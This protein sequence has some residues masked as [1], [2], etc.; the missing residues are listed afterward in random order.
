MLAALRSLQAACDLRA[1][2]SIT[3]QNKC[4]CFQWFSP[5]EAVLAI[6]MLA[7]ALH[8]DNGPFAA[9]PAGDVIWKNYRSGFLPITDR[10]GNQ[11][12]VPI[13]RQNRYISRPIINAT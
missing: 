6:D 12:S 11:Q 10:S 4:T 2:R 9:V 8:N 13:N 3:C 5:L 7:L 1:A